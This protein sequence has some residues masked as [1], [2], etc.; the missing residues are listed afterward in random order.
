MK[1][2]ELVKPTRTELFLRGETNQTNSPPLK[3]TSPRQSRGTLAAHL[4]WQLNL[5]SEKSN[6]NSLIHLANFVIFCLYLL[7]IFLHMEHFVNLRDNERSIFTA[8][9]LWCVI[10]FALHP[11]AEEPLQ[12]PFAELAHGGTSVGV[13]GE[14]VRDFDPTQD[15]L[16]HP[17][18]S[19]A[20]QRVTLPGTQEGALLMREKV[21]RRA[22][23]WNYDVASFKKK[24]KHLRKFIL[25]HFLRSLVIC[26]L[27]C[28]ALRSCLTLMLN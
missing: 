20:E 4:L 14:G 5:Q 15:H 26:K 7:L 16:L 13:D 18:G 1:T 11:L 28:A 19:T 8:C 21:K 25:Y 10:T 9:W 27:I 23:K 12:Q 2:A 22:V 3:S 17:D 6:N 24:E